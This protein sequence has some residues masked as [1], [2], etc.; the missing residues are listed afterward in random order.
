MDVY[1]F[2]L[3]SVST[4]ELEIKIGQEAFYEENGKNNINDIVI[5]QIYWKYRWENGKF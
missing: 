1:L 2:E 4:S 5:L 3:D